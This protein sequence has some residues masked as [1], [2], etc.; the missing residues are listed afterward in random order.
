MVLVYKI[1]WSISFLQ[2]YFLSF[3]VHRF[4]LEYLAVIT[5]YQA[6]EKQNKTLV[7]STLV[8][9]ELLL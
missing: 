7:L 6:R 4:G 9:K 8:N 1:R 5:Q 2:R 3:S